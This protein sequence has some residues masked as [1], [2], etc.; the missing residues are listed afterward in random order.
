MDPKNRVKHLNI[1]NNCA[2]WG[3]VE[4]VVRLLVNSVIIIIIKQTFFIGH[5]HIINV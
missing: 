3:L 5:A 2:T 1:T 4:L